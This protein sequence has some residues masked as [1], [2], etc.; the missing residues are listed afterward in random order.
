MHARARHQSRACIALTKSE[1]K[2]RL[3]AVALFAYLYKVR[4]LPAQGKQVT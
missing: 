1:E 2:D 3:L 4:V